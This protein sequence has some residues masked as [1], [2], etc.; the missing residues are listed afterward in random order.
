MLQAAAEVFGERG[1]HGASMDEIARRAGITKPMLYSYFKSKEGLFAACGEAAA[2]LLKEQ[3]REAASRRD[4]PPDQRLWQGL[5]GVFTFIGENRELWFAFIPPAGAATPGQVEE[6][7]ARGREAVNAL[8][9]ELL[10]ASAIAEGVAPEAAVQVAPLA[11]ALT[12]SVLAI[13]EWWHRHPDEPAELQ[14]LRVM[15]FA[16][17]GFEQLLKGQIW[18]PDG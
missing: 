12:A 8:M 16:W 11:H 6:V 9:E 17:K 4:L 13:A 3:V 15:N 5:I 2:E 1:Y 14:A 7:A 18:L 10:E